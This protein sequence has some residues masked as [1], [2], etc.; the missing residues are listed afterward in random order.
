MEARF[1]VKYYDYGLQWGTSA[2][3]L[4]KP[5]FAKENFSSIDDFFNYVQT[6]IKRGLESTKTIVIYPHS[7]EGVM[8][9]PKKMQFFYASKEDITKFGLVPRFKVQAGCTEYNCIFIYQNN[10]EGE[11]NLTFEA[12]EKQL[13]ERFPEQTGSKIPS[14]KFTPKKEEKNTTVASSE[15]SKTNN[16]RSGEENKPIENPTKLALLIIAIIAF[17]ASIGLF[18]GLGVAGLLLSAWLTAP[19]VLVV[20][21]LVLVVTRGFLNGP[22]Q[23]TDQREID[24]EHLSFEKT[25]L[26]KHNKVEIEPLF[27]TKSDPLPSISK[28]DAEEARDYIAHLFDPKEELHTKFSHNI[29]R[30]AVDLNKIIP[31]KTSFLALETTEKNNYLIVLTHTSFHSPTFFS[32]KANIKPCPESVFEIDPKPN[33]EK[34]MHA[35]PQHLHEFIGKINGKWGKDTAKIVPTKKF[36]SEGS[37]EPYSYTYRV[38]IPPE[39]IEH[40]LKTR[41]RTTLD[42]RNRMH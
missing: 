35:C 39:K 26:A 11:D 23:L 22:Q 13:K 7:K 29:A 27:H 41:N 2:P 31:S 36:S 8:A 33:D 25:E 24:K 10:I 4:N 1:T 40:I 30:D 28:K 21:S 3:L 37:K 17:F 14:E 16:R 15:P 38:E 5:M 12:F 6:L 32:S 42:Y 34:G 9:K 19:I 18:I 20:L